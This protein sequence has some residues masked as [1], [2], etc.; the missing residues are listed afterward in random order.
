MRNPACFE[1]PDTLSIIEELCARNSVDLQLVVDL[2]EAVQKFA[3]LG[4][5]E[6]LA[7]DISTCID[8]FLIHQK[9]PQ[10]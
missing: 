8:S 4:R 6:G 10:K 1:D 5:R 9:P 7:S 3:G 2:C